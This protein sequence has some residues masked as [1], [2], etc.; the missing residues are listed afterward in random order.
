[1]HGQHSVAERFL[2]KQELGYNGLQCHYVHT[3]WAAGLTF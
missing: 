1:M 2:R 3:N